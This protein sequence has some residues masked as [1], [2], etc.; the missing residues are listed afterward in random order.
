MPEL[1]VRI[2]KN[3]DG[4][5][6]LTCVRADGSVT[7]Q[8]QTGRQGAFFPIH[9]L[10]HYA[11]ETTLG[12]RQGFFGLL[13]E[14]WDMSDTEGKGARGPLPVEALAVELVVGFLDAERAGGCEWSAAE[15]AEKVALHATARGT[16]PDK[17]PPADVIT[18]ARLAA[19]RSAMRALFARW[20]DVEPGG[21]LE[22]P[23][24]RPMRQAPQAP[25]ETGRDIAGARAR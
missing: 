9:D 18:D 16:P 13:A 15:F 1:L 8:R 25:H 3:R 20:M 6:A 17:L 23:F 14:G 10:T 7:W 2:K 11:V 22:L 5:A 12:V 24:D 4:S 19:I 21:T